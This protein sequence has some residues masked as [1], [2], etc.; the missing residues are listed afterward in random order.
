MLN[1]LLFVYQKSLQVVS[2]ANIGKA[3]YDIIS[4]A[5]SNGPLT[6]MTGI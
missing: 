3:V 5:G 6:L 1:L 4:D 2:T